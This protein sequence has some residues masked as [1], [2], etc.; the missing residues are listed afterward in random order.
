MAHTELVKAR[1][2]SLREITELLE[3]DF[4]FVFN[5]RDNIGSRSRTRFNK[6][7]HCRRLFDR[8]HY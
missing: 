1:S 7:P 8:R 5:Q 3:G 4:A 2:N 6:F